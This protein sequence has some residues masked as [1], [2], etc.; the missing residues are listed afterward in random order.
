MFGRELCSTCLRFYISESMDCLSLQFLFR[1]IFSFMS[2][3]IFRQNPAWGRDRSYR[4]LAPFVTWI[5]MAPA[6]SFSHLARE[7]KDPVDDIVWAEIRQPESW[8]DH[9][10]V[11][12]TLDFITKEDHM[13]TTK[14]KFTTVDWRYVWKVRFLSHGIWMIRIFI[15]KL[16]KQFQN[17]SKWQKNSWAVSPTSKSEC[18][19]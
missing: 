7:T 8:G 14:F 9:W 17:R 2:I 4:E 15:F 11:D 3:F 16:C 18:S 5:P 12:R 6:P 13:D 10:T 19:A 1:L